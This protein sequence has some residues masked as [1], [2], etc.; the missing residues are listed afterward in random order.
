MIRYLLYIIYLIEWKLR[1]RDNTF[2]GCAPV[3]YNEWEDC[4]LQNM[5]D[6]PE[7]YKNN[8]YYFMIEYIREKESTIF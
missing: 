4:E 6:Y 8:W 1:H 5:F 2:N 3:C 7:D